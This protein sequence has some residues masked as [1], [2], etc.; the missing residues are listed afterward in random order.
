MVS[1]NGVLMPNVQEPI[2][3]LRLTAN[4]SSQLSFAPNDKLV[5]AGINRGFETV[6]MAEFLAML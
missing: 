1:W 4:V 5:R 6:D 3:M 2:T